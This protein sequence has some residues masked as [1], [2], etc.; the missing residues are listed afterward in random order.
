MNA[1]IRLYSVGLSSLRKTSTLSVMSVGSNGRTTGRDGRC[2]KQVA[3]AITATSK[4]NVSA[5]EKRESNAQTNT[6]EIP[7]GGNKIMRKEES[8]M[9][10]DKDKAEKAAS[11]AEAELSE[12]PESVVKPI[13]EWWLKYFM[14]AGHRR[15]GRILVQQGKH[16]AEQRE[17]SKKTSKKKAS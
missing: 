4:R 1:V 14:D 2:K 5:L 8:L 11:S 10:W 17:K 6:P 9:T 16:Y 7:T 15:L 13:S 12:M 3:T